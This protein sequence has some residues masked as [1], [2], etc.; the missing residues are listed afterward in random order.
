[1][2]RKVSFAVLFAVVFALG[3]P[4]LFAQDAASAAADNN[5]FIA[6]AIGWGLGLAVL[7]GAMGQGRA[8]AASVE[9]MARQPEAGGRIFGAMIIGLAL[10]ET[11]VIY[12]WVTT[13]LLMGNMVELPKPPA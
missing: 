5:M 1:M 12:I 8:I 2:T 11:L 3:A 10:I 4:A 13:F 6:I 7:G 9:A